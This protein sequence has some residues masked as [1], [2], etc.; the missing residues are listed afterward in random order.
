MSL[1]IN[2]DEKIFRSFNQKFEDYLVVFEEEDFICFESTSMLIIVSSSFRLTFQFI[3]SKD[4]L[5]SDVNDEYDQ[6]S[7]NIR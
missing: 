3:R 7:I 1:D 4:K 5:Q 2:D 6:S